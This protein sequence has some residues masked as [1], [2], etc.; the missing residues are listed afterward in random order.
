MIV[1]KG[2]GFLALVIPFACGILCQVVLGDAPMYAG[3]GYILGG[4]PVWFLGKKWNDQP[5]RTFT[6]NATGQQ[7]E[8][9][10][11]HSAFWI[12]MEYWA[13]IAAVVGLIVI[14]S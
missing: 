6:D 7:V 12:K 11:V 10:E 14:F 5:A 8:V 1:W 9:Q 2:L 3:I 4:I 13:I